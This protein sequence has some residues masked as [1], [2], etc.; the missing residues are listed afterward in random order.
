MYSDN[1]KVQ[2]TVYNFHQ[3]NSWKEEN[4]ESWTNR[5]LAKKMLEDIYQ[6]LIDELPKDKQDNPIRSPY[7]IERIKIEN[8]D[9]IGKVL[10]VLYIPKNR[11][12]RLK[13]LQ[14]NSQ[15][16]PVEYEEDYKVIVNLSNRRVRLGDYAI[17]YTS[18]MGER[19][20]D[21]DEHSRDE[22]EIE[23]IITP[24]LEGKEEDIIY[25]FR[26]LNGAENIREGY[27]DRIE[28]LTFSKGV[29]FDKNDISKIVVRFY[30]WFGLR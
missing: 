10:A 29:C 1:L 8:E 14:P 28:I 12:I 21:E 20:I 15:L 17:I 6:T 2:I 4:K 3:K 30:C 24:L 25:Q 23:K 9:Y 18:P 22:K 13:A 5:K 19:S 27:L 7:R 26:K 11:Y 16:N